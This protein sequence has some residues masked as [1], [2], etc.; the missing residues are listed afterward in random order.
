MLC[1][2][3]PFVIGAIEGGALKIVYLLYIDLPRKK[4]TITKKI[5]SIMADGNNSIDT[6]INTKGSCFFFC[7]DGV[8]HG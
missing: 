5:T 2:F 6:C 1:F 3:L 4:G 7:H 8:G